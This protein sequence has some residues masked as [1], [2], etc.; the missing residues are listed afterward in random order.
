MPRN[1]LNPLRKRCPA[2]VGRLAELHQQWHVW[3]RPLNRYTFAELGLLTST[4]RASAAGGWLV[5]HWRLQLGQQLR[6][7]PQVGEAEPS[8]GSG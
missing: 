5:A 8:S 1:M 4:A 2:P 3:N 6:V 7:I